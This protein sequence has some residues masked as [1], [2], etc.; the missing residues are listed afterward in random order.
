MPGRHPG[1]PLALAH[2]SPGK[3]ERSTCDCVS[4]PSST[5]SSA[6][7][8]PKKLLLKILAEKL[9]GTVKTMLAL[10]TST[11]R[12]G[13]IFREPV[14]LL[15][16]RN[17]ERVLLRR[18]AQNLSGRWNQIQRWPVWNRHRGCV[19]PTLSL[20]S[21]DT[22]IRSLAK[23]QIV[24]EAM[25]SHDK[26]RRPETINILGYLEHCGPGHRQKEDTFARGKK[27]L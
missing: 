12:K 1:T 16:P 5:S 2:N 7:T 26:V 18:Y 27:D 17:S 13:H 10:A 19:C 23:T 25:A 3:R 9:L 11:Y 8:L 20:D 6:T 15:R 22:Q 21:R 24:Q 14:F 4:V